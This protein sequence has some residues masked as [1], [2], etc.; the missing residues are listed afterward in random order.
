MPVSKQGKP[1]YTQEQVDII[2]SRIGVYEYCQ[3]QG[4]KMKRNSPNVYCLEEHDSL[5]IFLDT[6]RFSWYS[7]GI[8]GDAIEF[9]RV[10]EGKSMMEAVAILSGD[11]E[12][13]NALYKGSPI[14]YVRANLVTENNEDT[15][16][17]PPVK[18]KKQNETYS[19]LC[20]LRKIDNEIVRLFRQSGKIYIATKTI[21]SDN[22]KNFEIKPRSELQCEI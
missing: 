17:K 15:E 12:M 2:K 10:Y 9:L 8:H 3:S 18:A 5:K 16:Y 6:G 7:R 11:T 22:G 19:Y 4:Y 20:G 1:Y 21:E 13:L 14:K